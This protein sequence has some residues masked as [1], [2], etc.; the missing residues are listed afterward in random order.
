MPKGVEHC[1]AC[2]LSYDR[3]HVRTSVMPKGVE[4]KTIKGNA[5]AYNQVRTSVMPK[6]VEHQREE[7][8]SMWAIV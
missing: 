4:H 1:Q 7:M 5:Y 3:G 8:R 2:H 6:G